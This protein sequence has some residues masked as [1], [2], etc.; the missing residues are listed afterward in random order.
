M[1]A[2]VE[3]A[4]AE[5]RFVMRLLGGFALLALL[6]AGMG[7]YGV[8]SN[9][10]TERTREVGVRVALGARR[11]DIVRLVLGAGA[12][13]VAAGLAAGVAAAFVAT[14]FL[15]ALLFGVEANDPS[16]FV[17]ATAVLLA[18]ALGAHL[19]P[20]LRALRVD[21]VVALRQE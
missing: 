5:R 14:R 21:P 17:A 4:A 16:T 13:T 7:L 6:L 9:S 15:E 18:V 3:K 12:R 8:I 19:L 11:A 10:V 20:A 2:L 1:N